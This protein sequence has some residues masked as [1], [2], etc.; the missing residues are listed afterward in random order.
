MDRESYRYVVFLGVP[1][2]MGIAARIVVWFFDRAD[3][4][5]SAARLASI[6]S[7]QAPK[8]PGLSVSRS[9]SDT[10]LTA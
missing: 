3:A 4:A 9:S 2:A 7:Q 8:L 10:H 6:A 1:I 5:E